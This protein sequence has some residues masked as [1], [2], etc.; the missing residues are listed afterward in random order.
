MNSQYKCLIPLVMFYMTIKLITIL[1]IYKIV[2]IGPIH[3]TAATII[4]PLW[5]LTGD[6]ISEVYGY[7]IS[8][9]II[10]AALIC[11]F[12]FAIICSLAIHLPSPADF[13]NQ[14]AYSHVLG[15]LPRVVMASFIA[16]LSGAFINAY[17]VARWK[18]L[19]HGKLFWLRSLGASVI[20][21]AIFVIISLSM[22]FIGVTPW[23]TLLQLILVSFALKI[24]VNFIFIIPSSLIAAVLKKIENIDVYEYDLEFNP[25]KIKFNKPSNDLILA[26]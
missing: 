22:E 16:I 3:T 4:I 7:N 14:N 21:E 8:K 1:T 24:A 6:I 18:V 20:G 5:F 12:I 13:T 23:K 15:N 10:W 25:I 26:K 2:I 19:L 9:Q 17:A 11:Q